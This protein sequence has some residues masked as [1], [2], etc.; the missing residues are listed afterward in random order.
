MAFC[1]SCSC[2]G[3]QKCLQAGCICSI[4]QRQIVVQI[5]I[6][7][8]KKDYSNIVLG[9]VRPIEKLL[10]CSNRSQSSS[11]VILAVVVVESIPKI[12][13]INN[14]VKLAVFGLI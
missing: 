1:Y 3:F 10:E 11:S 14:T 6:Y 12:N 2:F 13:I 8:S 9:L 7:I 5:C 4:L